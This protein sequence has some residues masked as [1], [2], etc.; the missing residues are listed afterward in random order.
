VSDPVD[1]FKNA[2]SRLVLGDDSSDQSGG[3]ALAERT[4]RARLKP[5][6]RIAQSRINQLLGQ[7]RVRVLLGALV[8]LLAVAVAQVF[9]PA[10][11]TGPGLAP[12]PIPEATTGGNFEAQAPVS[13]DLDVAG[14]VQLEFDGLNGS[15][16]IQTGA[17][18]KLEITASKSAQ[19]STAD[20]ATA[21]A[22]QV[23]LSIRHEQGRVTFSSR[24]DGANPWSPATLHHVDYDIVAPEQSGLT[25][26]DGHGT[27]DASGLHL[28]VNVAGDDL[29]VNLTNVGAA[30]VA[31]KR[32]GIVVDGAA[33]PTR[34]DGGT[35][36]VEAQHLSGPSG[37]LNADGGVSVSET[38]VTGRLAVTSKGTRVS[39][40]RTR[41]KDID[42][43]TAGGAIDLTDT[44]ADATLTLDAAQGDVTAERAQ[45]HP[46]TVTTTTGDVNLTEVQG[47][48]KVT[49]EGAPVGLDEAGPSS[50]AVSSRGG[51]VSFTGRLPTTGATSIDTGGGNLDLA[52]PRESA[53]TLDADAGRGGLTVDSAMLSGK[54][55]SGR[56]AIVSLNGGGP[57][58]VLRT[59]DGPL[60]IT[61]K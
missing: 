7:A 50:L 5:R 60:S 9:W 19:G 48:V 26:V 56:A 11:G 33:G 51:D 59:H 4:E 55:L 25:V 22:S 40:Q 3:E 41:G 36:D 45:A 49:T 34:L 47:D 1:R 14:P 61:T 31:V 54:T 16:N 43:Q 23:P 52:I 32:G 17:P 18:G 44:T 39:L 24:T 42:V 30:S 2:V 37:D 58:V 28:P 21:R 6:L 10:A 27:I 46:L 57:R 12:A 15:L 8:I 38:Q 20:D 29:A 13:E 35:S 53:F